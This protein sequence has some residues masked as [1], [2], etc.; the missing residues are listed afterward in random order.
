MGTEDTP[1]RQTPTE[2]LHEVT[3][4]FAQRSSSPPEQSVE[5]SRNAK[6]AAQFT[7]TARGHNLEEALAAAQRAFSELTT[8]HPYANGAE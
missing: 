8:K 6:G 2:R 7:V 3:L 4:A 5:I 1:R